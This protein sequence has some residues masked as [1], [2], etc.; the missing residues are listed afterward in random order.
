L[1]AR[2]TIGMFIQS[3]YEEFRWKRLT[4]KDVDPESIGKLQVIN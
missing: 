2:P 4:F 3:F 1:P